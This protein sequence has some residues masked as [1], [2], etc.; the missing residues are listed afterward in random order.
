M[1]S[2]YIPREKSTERTPHVVRRIIA[3]TE[4]L[5]IAPAALFMAALL[6]R[7]VRPPQHEPSFTAQSIV[8]WFSERHWTLWVLL[9]AMPFAA[10]VIGWISLVRIWRSDIELR[11]SASRATSAVREHAAVLLV[12]IVTLAA[13]GI[14]V[15]MVVHTLAN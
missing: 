12:S 9:M 2:I 13:A 4:L 11:Q 10:L 8:Y 6:I 14:L 7:G 1:S 5:L 3:V 15:I